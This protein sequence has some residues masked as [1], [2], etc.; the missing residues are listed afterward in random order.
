MSVKEININEINN[1]GLF[2]PHGIGDVVNST[3]IVLG[4][5]SLQKRIKITLIVRSKVESEL[6]GGPT[7]VDDVI[8]FD[9]HQKHTL[10]SVLSFLSILR[11]KKFDMLIADNGTD[12]IK[13]PIFFFLL[14]AKY[15]IGEKN[16][17]LSHL[18]THTIIP[19]HT[20]HKV[21]NNNNFLKFIGIEDEYA[22]FVF[23][24]H[25]DKNKVVCYLSEIGISENDDFIVIHPG[26]GAWEAHKRWPK[27]KY[28]AFIKLVRTSSSIPIILVGGKDEYELV[29]SI[30]NASNLRLLYNFAAK[31]SI[32]ELAVVLKMS[33]LVIGADS[34]VMHI[35]S[36]VGT[37]TMSI[38]GP[39]PYQYTGPYRNNVVITKSL[40]CSPCYDRM[41]FGCGNPICMSL[42]D[43]LEV[44]KV[45][46][47]K[48]NS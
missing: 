46:N 33:K 7:A 23:Y 37:N 10:R 32:R 31:L 12:K 36:A 45:F 39:T 16:N 34:G 19:D 24:D 41:Q 1:I 40:S 43:E 48:F 35:A 38:F 5:R 44:Y 14:G 15:R 25:S 11:N 13:T 29:E 27:E 21:I 28:I 20:R 30:I 9:I 6:F 17:L 18:F 2:F 47:E 4:L 3:P 8:I 26:S 42:I 22:P